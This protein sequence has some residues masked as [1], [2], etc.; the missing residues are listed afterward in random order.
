T[1]EFVDDDHEFGQAVSR[2]AVF[3]VDVQS[4]PAEFDEALPE[5]R[6]ALLGRIQ[7]RPGGRA[8]LLRVEKTAGYLGEFTMVVGQC[9]THCRAFL[10]GA[11]GR[12]ERV[13]LNPTAS[14]PAWRTPPDGPVASGT[15]R[16]WSAR[17]RTRPG[18]PWSIR[19]RTGSARSPARGCPAT[20]GRAP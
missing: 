1:T 20:R 9:D 10:L 14:Q 13:Y 11:S 12:W 2:T 16:P 7:Q 19:S 4:Q 6:Q 18:C 5:R 8:G 17:S 15:P 3:L